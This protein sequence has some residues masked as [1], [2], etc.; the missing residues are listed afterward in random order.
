[1]ESERDEGGIGGGVGF[2]WPSEAGRGGG[3]GKGAWKP[4]EREREAAGETA[5]R[6]KA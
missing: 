5:R 4:G 6:L 1:M 3:G 2:L